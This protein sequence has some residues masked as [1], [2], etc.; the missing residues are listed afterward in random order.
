MDFVGGFLVVRV[1]DFALV[2]GLC[3]ASCGSSLGLSLVS[4]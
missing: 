1:G 3:I 2:G 4:S